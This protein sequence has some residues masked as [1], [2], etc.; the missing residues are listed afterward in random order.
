MNVAT[1]TWCKLLDAVVAT[2]KNCS[3]RGLACK[4]LIGVVSEVPMTDPV[5]YSKG[6]KLSYGFMVSEA[7][8]ILSGS[9]LVAFAPKQLEK[10][11]DDGV[12]MNGAYGPAYIEQLSY[13]VRCLNTDSA[14]RQ[15]V[16]S[17]WRPRPM[18]SKDIP[19]TLTLQFLIRDDTLHCV[20]TMRS[21]DTW[22]GYPYDIFTFSMLARG[23]NSC[24][25]E[26]RRI[27]NLTMM[28]GS[29]H[30]YET[31]LKAAEEIYL[32]PLYPPPFKSAK[33]EEAHTY[34]MHLARLACLKDYVA[35]KNSELPPAVQDFDL[36][37]VPNREI[38]DY[39]RSNK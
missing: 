28:V 23:V 29:Q 6:R 24:L 22:L 7:H 34:P 31:H 30:L 17:L 13:V 21:S 3:P 37:M 38:V 18:P 11:S 36:T 39:V 26:K 2:G 25:S 16:M 27:G 33:Y 14:S 20:A 4:E 9:N 1:T 15:A 12:T 8:W 10:W 32:E 35:G 19:C 5:I